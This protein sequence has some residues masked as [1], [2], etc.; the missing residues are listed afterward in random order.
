MSSIIED[1]LTIE[2]VNTTQQ[3]ISLVDRLVL[4]HDRSFMYEPVM[5][6]DLEGVDLCREGSVSLLTLL[7]DV[8]IRHVYLIDVHTSGQAAFNTAGEKLKT[9]KDVL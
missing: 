8:P 2:V 7:L 3:I 5:Y 6:I 1:R 9:L 4:R